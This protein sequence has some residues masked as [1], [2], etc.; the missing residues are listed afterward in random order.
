M[1]KSRII[2]V[3]ILLSLMASVVALVV[4]FKVP[5]EVIVK[6]DSV[7]IGDSSDLTASDSCSVSNLQDTQDVKLEPVSVEEE[8]GYVVNYSYESESSVLGLKSDVDSSCGGW[9]Y[10][11]STFLCSR[12]EDEKDLSGGG[13]ADVGR[14][15]ARVDCP[16]QIEYVS[17]P[18]TWFGDS[19][20][21]DDP[22]NI[23][24]CQ[25]EYSSADKS[26]GNGPLISAEWKGSDGASADGTGG[27]SG[28]AY[29]KSYYTDEAHDFGMQLVSPHEYAEVAQT[30]K[31]IA[32]TEI[33][34]TTGAAGNNVDSGSIA[35]NKS[36]TVTEF[37]EKCN[38]GK[39]CHNCPSLKAELSENSNKDKLGPR[40]WAPTGD[41]AFGTRINKEDIERDCIVPAAEVKGVKG[42][43]NVFGKPLG[44]IFGIAK[45]FSLPDFEK[46]AEFG[47]CY[48]SYNVF[49]FT[50]NP[51]GDNW[52]APAFSY[53]GTSDQLVALR[54]GPDNDRLQEVY[55]DNTLPRDFTAFF[56]D[57]YVGTE[58]IVNVC[59]KSVKTMCIH[60][61]EKEKNWYERALGEAPVTEEEC[62]CYD[63]PSYEKQTWLMEG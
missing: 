30:D 35:E 49:V 36:K 62:P 23:D 27:L 9:A 61:S 26:L 5:R 15:F 33:H 48:A 18:A 16:I 57:S 37:C 53:D 50:M 51:K 24:I 21:D 54:L 29:E 52:R 14:V 43:L 59:G 7:V 10:A 22:G 1:W 40:L 34:L 8:S 13:I 38:R 12:K 3:L 41:I 63:A 39:S 25:C 6:Q 60:P 11:P 2:A 28:S 31:G 46:C 55:E 44:I 56:P 32:G 47:S 20:K 17:Y 19:S 45:M 4:L 42:C 58:C